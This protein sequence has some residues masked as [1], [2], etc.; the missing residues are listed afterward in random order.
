MPKYENLT[1]Q[2]L[3]DLLDY[4]PDTGIFTWKVD[5]RKVKAGDRAGFVHAGGGLQIG[6]GRQGY[7]ASHLAWLYMTGKFPEKQLKFVD[8]NRLNLKWKN[9][10]LSNKAGVR[11]LEEVI[12]PDCHKIRKVLK[13]NGYKYPTMNGLVAIPCRQCSYAKRQ[14]PIFVTSADIGDCTIVPSYG[15]CDQGGQ[16]RK[17]TGTDIC[18]FYDKCLTIALENHWPGWTNDEKNRCV[19]DVYENEQYDEEYEYDDV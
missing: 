1:Q 14:N 7:R 8:N 16:L 3:K 18:P 2:E 10:Y 13:G 6:V 9:L 19:V 11:K 12:C 17:E 5:R 4:N 15:R